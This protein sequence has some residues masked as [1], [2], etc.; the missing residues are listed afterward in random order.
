MDFLTCSNSQFSGG[1][2]EWG[3][4][5]AFTTQGSWVDFSQLGI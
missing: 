3:V 2:G 1:V 5:L 4:V